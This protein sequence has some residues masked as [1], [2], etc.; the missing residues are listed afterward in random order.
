MLLLLKLSKEHA[1]ELYSECGGDS[2]SA[3]GDVGFWGHVE[4][5]LEYF[6]NRKKKD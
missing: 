5:G 2:C 3:G 1:T 6:L 4:S